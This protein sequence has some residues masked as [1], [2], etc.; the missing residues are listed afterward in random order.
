MTLDHGAGRIAIAG[1]SDIMIA[2][3]APFRIE[4]SV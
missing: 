2:S 4:V 1:L 3:Q